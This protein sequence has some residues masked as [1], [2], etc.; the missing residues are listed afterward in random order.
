M[1][2]SKLIVEPAGSWLKR[3]VVSAVSINQP[4]Q[5]KHFRPSGPVIWPSAIKAD[6]VESF[7]Q[8]QITRPI[9]ATKTNRDFIVNIFKNTDTQKV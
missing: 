7:L 1:A 5:Q 3:K 9:K 8:A 6:G 4:P 2:L